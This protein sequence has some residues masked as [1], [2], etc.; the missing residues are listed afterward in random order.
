M[1]HRQDGFFPRRPDCKGNRVLH[2]LEA[3]QHLRSVPFRKQVVSEDYVQIRHFTI[4]D[5]ARNMLTSLTIDHPQILIAG[6]AAQRFIHHSRYTE[7][8][9]VQKQSTLTSTLNAQY[10]LIIQQ[11]EHYR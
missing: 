9:P 7:Y 8:G 11:E 3:Q 6:R 2:H 10:P 1:L 5:E 4:A